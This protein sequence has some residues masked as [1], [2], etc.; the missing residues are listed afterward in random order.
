VNRRLAIVALLGLVALAVVVGTTGAS[1]VDGDGLTA[2][3][4][5]EAGTSVTDADSDGDGLA[6]GAER[7]EHDTDPLNRDTDDDGL[8]DGAE[9]DAH[10][11]DPLDADTDEDGLQDGVEVEDHDTDPTDP[12]RFHRFIEAIKLA[13]ADAREDDRV[14]AATLTGSGPAGRAVAAAA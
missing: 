7:R 12:E 11:S 6:D 5:F 8:A 2:L 14:K 1:D 13:F 3:E 10:G 4:E 9:L